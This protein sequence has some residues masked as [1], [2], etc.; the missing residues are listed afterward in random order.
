MQAA[1]QGETGTAV[2][3]DHANILGSA[4]PYSA[5]MRAFGTLSTLLPVSKAGIS[6]VTAPD[7]W[8]EIEMT[9]DSGACVTVM[10]RALCPRISIPQ[11]SL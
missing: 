3:H 2:G 9:I 11:N 8:I 1:A 5:S 10:P 7:E 4:N 6:A